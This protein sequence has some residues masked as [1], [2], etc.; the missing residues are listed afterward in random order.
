VPDFVLQA[1]EKLL[2]NI[3]EEKVLRKIFVPTREE[4]VRRMGGGCCKKGGT[5]CLNDL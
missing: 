3:F 2:M 4:A 5:H 1:K